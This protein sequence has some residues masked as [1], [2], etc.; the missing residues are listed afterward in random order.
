MTQGAVLPCRVIVVEGCRV[1]Y[2]TET[3]RGS[4]RIM[5]SLVVL[6]IVWVAFWASTGG[7]ERMLTED[8][9]TAVVHSA[10]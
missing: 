3:G 7:L 10:I 9:T 4:N 2:K 5:Q 1:T 8:T 6:F